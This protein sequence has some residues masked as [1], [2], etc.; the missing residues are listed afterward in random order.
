M[1][2]SNGAALL[3]RVKPG[4][5]VTVRAGDGSRVTGRAEFIGKA[6]ICK[7]QPVSASRFV[8]AGNII[9]ISP[10]R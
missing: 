10:R 2:N 7:A 5:L 4:D 8:T 9:S 1:N 3:A 6:A